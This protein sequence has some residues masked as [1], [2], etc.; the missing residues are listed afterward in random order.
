MIKNIFLLRHGESE[1]NHSHSADL[2]RPSYA[3]R[4]TDIGVKQ[5]VSAGV[6]LFSYPGNFHMLV[7]PWFRTRQS[8][9]ALKPI[10]EG[11]IVSVQYSELIREREV[12]TRLSPPPQ[13][14]SM[15]DRRSFYHRHEG[16]ESLA[17]VFLRMAVFH[18]QY[19]L[20]I[21]AGSPIVEHEN[22]LIISHGEAIPMYIKYLFGWSVEVCEK[23]KYP[24][25]GGIIRV[26]WEYYGSFILKTDLDV[27]TNDYSKYQYDPEDIVITKR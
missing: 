26:S 13:H 2:E 6:E 24:P 7:S 14:N 19:V 23:L 1:G 12:S 11:R 27:W 5:S 3:I 4:L 25:N 16:G 20:P 8:F 17:D 22:I 21:I 9:D 18:N 10:L 15:V